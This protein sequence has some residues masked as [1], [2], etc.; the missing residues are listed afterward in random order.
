MIK[1]AKHPVKA[2]YTMEEITETLETLDGAR[3][4]AITELASFGL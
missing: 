3:A 2:I 1:S 4:S